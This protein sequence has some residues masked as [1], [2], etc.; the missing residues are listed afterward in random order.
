M[1]DSNS[2]ATTVS[3]ESYPRKR[4]LL[5][6]LLHRTYK[7]TLSPFVGQFCRFSR[8]CSDYG[9]EAVERYGWI[10]GGWLALKR[11]GRC[12]PYHAGGHDPVP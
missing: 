12:H 7:L 9:L 8:T 3:I 6:R 5:A 4:R 10:R 11:I 2:N 1:C